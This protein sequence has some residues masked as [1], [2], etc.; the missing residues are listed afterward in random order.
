MF[1]IDKILNDF[2]INHNEKSELYLVKANFKL[3]FDDNPNAHIKTD[4]FYNISV[5]NL[6]QFLLHRIHSVNLKGYKFLHISELNIKTI[7]GK[8]NMC[9]EYYI[10]NPKHMVEG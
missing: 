8:R 5:I 9:Y 3:D 6:K 4:L 1:V 10:N 7:C 2:I